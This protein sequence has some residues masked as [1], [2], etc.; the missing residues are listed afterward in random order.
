MMMI[1]LSEVTLLGDLKGVLLR[2]TTQII[3]LEVL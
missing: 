3:A 2:Q 1:L